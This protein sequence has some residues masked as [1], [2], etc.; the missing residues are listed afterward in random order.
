[1]TKYWVAKIIDIYSLTVIEARSLR[2]RW[3]QGW[4]LVRPLFLAYRWPPFHSVLT[5]RFLCAH[6]RENTGVPSSSKDNSSSELGPHPYD[7]KEYQLFQSPLFK[8]F[9]P[10]TRYIWV[11]NLFRWLQ[12]QKNFY[13]NSTRWWVRITQVNWS[14]FWPTKNIWNNKMNVGVLSH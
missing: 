14:N 4:C 5:W 7:I 10:S 6:K 9:K 12:P 2:S 8:A 11:K 13:Y 3:Q 1:M